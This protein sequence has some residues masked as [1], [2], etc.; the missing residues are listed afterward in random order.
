[1]K[2]ELILPPVSALIGATIL[3]CPV[4]ANQVVFSGAFSGHA[5]ADC[6]SYVDG[7]N[8][9]QWQVVFTGYGS[10]WTIIIGNSCRHA[11]FTGYRSIANTQAKDVRYYYGIGT[12]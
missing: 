4:S 6:P 11:A 12:E 7:D 5:T 8:F 10:H 3:T 1:M 2:R 9:G